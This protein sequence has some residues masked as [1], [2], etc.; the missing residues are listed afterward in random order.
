MVL[1]LLAASLDMS[2]IRNLQQNGGEYQERSQLLEEEE[3]LAQLRAFELPQDAFVS[4]TGQKK[5]KG[6]LQ[7]PVILPRVKSK[8][9]KRVGQ[10]L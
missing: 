10:L 3:A 7:K 9:P 2:L 1:L 6:V 8:N 5:K 4:L